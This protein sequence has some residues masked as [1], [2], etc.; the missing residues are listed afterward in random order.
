MTPTDAEL[1]TRYLERNDEGSFAE[2]VRRHL[3]VVYSAAL[4]RTGGRAHLADEIS[5][6]VFAKLA[7]NAAWL[8]RHPTLIGWLYRCTRNA[9]VDAIRAE[10]RRQKLAQ[11]LATMPDETPPSLPDVDWD[12]LRPVLDQAIDRLKERDREVVLL[13]FFHGLTFA[14]VGERLSL[15]ENAARMRAT[16]ALE[17]LRDNLGRQGVTS[18]AAALGVLLAHPALA[19]APAGLAATVST[20]ALTAAPAGIAAGV[21]SFLLMSKVTAPLIGAALGVGLITT[22]WYHT[23][24][25]INSTELSRLQQENARLAQVL[26]TDE[27][28]DR[29]AALAETIARQ[30]AGITAAALAR[31]GESSAGETPSSGAA[32]GASIRPMSPRGHRWAGQATPMDA[33]RSFAWASDVTDVEAIARLIWFEPELR[34]RARAVLATMPASIQARYPTPEEF[35]ALVIAA[36]SL[37]YPP[38]VPETLPQLEEVELREGRAALRFDGS[39]RNYHEY[40]QTTEGWKF[41]MPAVGVERWPNNLNNETLAKL[42][43]RR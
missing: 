37:F 35:Y 2:V 10:C 25:G 23:A 20:T 24:H 17:K 3:G 28:A 40:Q 16:R 6:A 42:S 5:Q 7:R 19:T 18:T 30:H 31:T 21:A 12:R 36:D 11:V 22:L 38:P 13:R 43:T 41:V 39:P 14:E 9:A 29:A 15:N 32:A 34:E 27:L 8:A 4:R 33:S 1:L 26:K